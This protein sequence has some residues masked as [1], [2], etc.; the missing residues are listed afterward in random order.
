[1]VADRFIKTVEIEELQMQLEEESSELTEAERT[2]INARIF[3]LQKEI[4]ETEVSP[5]FGMMTLADSAQE[6]QK[7]A[8][9]KQ[10]AKKDD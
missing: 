9:Q 3:Q 6:Q 7:I 8:T 10:K 4:N 5:S 1:M 2:K